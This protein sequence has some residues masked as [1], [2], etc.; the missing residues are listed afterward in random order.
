MKFDLSVRFVL[1][2]AQ[3]DAKG[4]APIYLR[5]TVNRERAEL[6]ANKKIEAKRWNNAAQR[7]SGRSEV[8]RTLNDYLENLE[9]LVRRN[10]NSLIDSE[11]EISATILRDRLIGKFD[12]T[13]L[14]PVSVRGNL[15]LYFI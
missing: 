10:F 5:I 12:K 6:S 2:R 7:A 13:M 14:S 3:T 11:E 1:R 4:L 9:T 8:A 15:H